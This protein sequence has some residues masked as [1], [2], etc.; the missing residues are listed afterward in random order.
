MAADDFLIVG[1]GASAGGIK[2]LR[3][4]FEHVTI[5]SGMAYV[6]ILHL[7]PEYESR[8][9]EVLQRSTSVPVTTRHRSGPCR[10]GSCLRAPAE[11]ERVDG[12]RPSRA[13]PHHADRG[14]ASSDRHLLP[15]A[16]RLSGPP[17]RQHR[18]LGHGRRRIHGDEAREGTGWCL[19]RTGS[20]RSRPRGH[21]PALDCD[22]VCRLRPPRRGNARAVGCVQRPAQPVAYRAGYESQQLDGRRHR[23]RDL[24]TRSSPNGSRFFQ[25]QT[26]DRPTSSRASD[27]GARD[28][29][30]WRVFAVL[31]L[32]KRRAAGAAQGSADQ[33]HE[34][35][36]R[37]TGV[38]RTRTAD[39]VAHGRKRAR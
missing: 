11:S 33:R 25:L 28:R 29:Y 20:E 8:L 7:S 17:V 10:A 31:V 6:V 34:L 37:S 18:P 15:H 30:D 5:D 21:A 1:L 19:P 27:A 35:L 16:R 39:S 4:F 32:A 3:A 38:R 36:S 2:A 13:V 14:A 23:R 26:G 22:G 12:R 24:H 9:P